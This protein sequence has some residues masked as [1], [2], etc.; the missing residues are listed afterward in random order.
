M[1]YRFRN[2]RSLLPHKLPGAPVE[3]TRIYSLVLSP[4]TPPSKFYPLIQLAV[5]QVPGSV[6]FE[7]GSSILPQST[8]PPAPPTVAPP[9][10]P[11]GP[12]KV[13]PHEGMPGSEDSRNATYFQQHFD[14]QNFTG[15]LLHSDKIF[16]RH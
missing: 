16:V 5:V 7:Y 12:P 11:A 14:D 3:P 9:A 6:G 15:D 2:A 10:Q 13:N 8:Q 1:I 4:V